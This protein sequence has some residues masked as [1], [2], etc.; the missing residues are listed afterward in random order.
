ME[1]RYLPFERY[2]FLFNQNFF[3][4][5][6]ELDLHQKGVLADLPYDGFTRIFSKL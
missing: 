5:N 1:D 4:V 6:D 2:T 3:N